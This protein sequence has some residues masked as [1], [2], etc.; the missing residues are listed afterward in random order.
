MKSLR[1]V[2]IDAVLPV[3][4]LAGCGGSSDGDASDVKP[5]A[6]AGTE[7][8]L[9][10]VCPDVMTGFDATGGLGVPTNDEEAEAFAAWSDALTA[11][12]ESSDEE[13]KTALAPLVAAA[14]E[15]SDREVLALDLDIDQATLT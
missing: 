11:L 1:L 10:E 6:T 14:R 13:A 2:A 7:K 3:V 8:T 12:S 4:L 9:A 5:A 15:A